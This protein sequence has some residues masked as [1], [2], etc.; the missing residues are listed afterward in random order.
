MFRSM[1]FSIG[2][3][4][5]VVLGGC[6]SS[7]STPAASELTPGEAVMCA[8]CQTTWVKLPVRQKGRVVAYS[9]RKSMT[10][11]DCRGM[12]ENFFANGKLEHTCPTCGPNAMEVCKTH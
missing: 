10:C 12:A 8:K 4:T 5:L 7:S 3:A 9:S 11:P 1:F 6:Q 2:A